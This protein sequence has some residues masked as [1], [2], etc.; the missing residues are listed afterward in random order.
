[1]ETF[2]LFNYN[3]FTSKLILNCKRGQDITLI[4]ELSKILAKKINYSL[5]PEIN[6]F[7]PVASKEKDTLDHAYYIG[8]FLALELQ[9]PFLP[10]LLVQVSQRSQKNIGVQQRIGFQ[11]TAQRCLPPVKG[12]VWVL[13]DDVITTGVTLL[14]SHKCLHTT[15][16]VSL[17]LASRLYR[18]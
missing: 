3:Q 6:G 10:H 7:I 2:S 18:V 11:V 15:P 16:S 5:L 17:T 12:G 13:V 8:Y 4:R 9:K 1:M 14:E